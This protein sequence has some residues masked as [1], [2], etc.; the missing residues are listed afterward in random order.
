MSAPAAV[1]AAAPRLSGLVGDPGTE[2]ALRVAVATVFAAAASAKL[3]E[4]ARFRAA[5]RGYRLI[6]PL[7]VAPLGGGLA[8][9][10]LLLAAALVALPGHIESVAAA[11]ALL[12]GFAAAMALAITRAEADA[13]CGCGFGVRRQRLRPALVVR[14]V[15]LAAL[16]LPCLDP[17][18]PGW[19]DIPFALA[20]AAGLVLMLA[21]ADALLALPSV[22][23]RAPTRPPVPS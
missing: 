3:R 21:A 14:N 6:P 23:R 8:A 19:R 22:R 13:A 4:P 17:V 7:L 12:L 11:I 20:A 15:A 10:E 5:L 16:L 1:F 18:R 9:A 2:L